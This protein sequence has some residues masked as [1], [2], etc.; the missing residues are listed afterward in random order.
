MKDRR[1]ARAVLIYAVF[2]V[3]LQS[4]GTVLDRLGDM[5]PGWWLYVLLA[6]LIA[7]AMDYLGSEE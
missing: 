7:A 5:Q 3:V 4:V 2:G 6:P 1:L